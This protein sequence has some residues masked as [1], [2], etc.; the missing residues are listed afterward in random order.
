MILRSRT[1]GSFTQKMG[2]PRIVALFVIIGESFG[3]LAFLLGFS[4]GS[5]LQAWPLSCWERSPWSTSP[6]DSS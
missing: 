1:I 6:T 5:R 3:S 2:M 4:P